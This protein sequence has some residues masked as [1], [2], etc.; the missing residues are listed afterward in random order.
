[1]SATYSFLAVRQ[2]YFKLFSAF[3]ISPCY[4]WLKLMKKDCLILLTAL[5]PA[6]FPGIQRA[7][8]HCLESF[9]PFNRPLTRL[10]CFNA[11]KGC[12]CSFTGIKKGAG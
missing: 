5:F 3:P 7:A 6:L 4:H 9:Q 2:I 12:F 8:F 10:D 11:L 1:M